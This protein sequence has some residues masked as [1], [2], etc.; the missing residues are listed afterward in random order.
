MVGERLEEKTYFT[1]DQVGRQL[2]KEQ[3]AAIFIKRVLVEI[4][5]FPKR[6][7]M[8]TRERHRREKQLFG[9]IAE[10]ASAAAATRLF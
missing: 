6:I 8:F 1:R 2:R 10:K 4:K 9:F 7:Q 5:D 3:T